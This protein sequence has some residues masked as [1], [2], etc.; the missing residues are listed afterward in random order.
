MI[1]HL[2]A[3]DIHSIVQWQQF[4]DKQYEFV[5]FF[6]GRFYGSDGSKTD[7]MK[8]VEQLVELAIEEKKRAE[9]MRQKY[10]DCNVEFKAET[11]T[12]VWC[13]QQSGGIDRDWT[14]YPRK[15][16][17]GDS[18]EFRC[19]CVN[20]D[21]LDDENLKKYDNCEEKAIECHYRV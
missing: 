13:T 11:G 10:P 16:F 19:V 14:G 17:K 2:S 7:Y 5:G 8:K 9:E 6:I 3:Q 12:R 15:L 4:Y 18:E 20:D 1:K 21:G